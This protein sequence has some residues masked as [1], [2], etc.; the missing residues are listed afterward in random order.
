MEPKPFRQRYFAIIGFAAAGF[1]AFRVLRGDIEVA[2]AL[3]VVAAVLLVAA[4]RDVA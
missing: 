3:G 2:V 4:A 1:A